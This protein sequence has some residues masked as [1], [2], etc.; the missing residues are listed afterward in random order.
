MQWEF[1]TA[2]A[3]AAAVRDTGVCILPTGVLERHSDHLPLGTDFLH[4]HFVAC[5]AAEIEP[6]VVFPPFYFGQIYEARAFPGAFTLS[7]ALLLELFQGV[8]DEIGRNGFR[9]ILIYNGHGGNHHFLRFLAQSALWQEKPYQFYLAQ[10]LVERSQVDAIL[11]SDFGGHADEEETSQILFEFPG[12]VDMSQVPPVPARP[13]GR[14]G[15]L[16]AYNGFWWYA[17]YPEHYAGDARPATAEKGRKLDELQAQ[18]LARFIAKVKADQVM[19]ALAVEFFERE[20]GL[21]EG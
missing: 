1:L 5:R 12:A 17:D 14:M 13:L 10:D 2:P 6:A 11:T 7:P 15:D 16:D 8:L 3:F 9:K 21:R 20:R 4:A 18:G 19:P